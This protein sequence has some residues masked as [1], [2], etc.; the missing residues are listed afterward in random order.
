MVW[1]SK[2][3]S[4]PVKTTEEL[5]WAVENGVTPVFESADSRAYRIYNEAKLVLGDIISL[6]MTDFEKTLS[7]F[8]WICVNTV[9]D[10]DTFANKDGITTQF[11]CY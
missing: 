7:I 9:Y 3:L 6:D 11:P 2:Y 1:G 8:D 5:Y 10:Y 4:T